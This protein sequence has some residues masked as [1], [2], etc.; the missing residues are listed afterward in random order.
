MKGK[1]KI[2]PKQERR[3]KKKKREK[4]RGRGIKKEKRQEGKDIY[5]IKFYT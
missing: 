2:G 4:K 1:N 5:E 3:D